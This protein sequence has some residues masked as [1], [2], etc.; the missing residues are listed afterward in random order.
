MTSYTKAH[1]RGLKNYSQST[2]RGSWSSN[3]LGAETVVVAAEWVVAADPVVA[4]CVVGTEAVVPCVVVVSEIYK[5][6]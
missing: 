1:H 5:A 4:E 2:L 3:I 6:N